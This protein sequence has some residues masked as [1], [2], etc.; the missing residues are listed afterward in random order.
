MDL[1]RQ[2]GILQYVHEKCFCFRGNFGLG[3]SSG[4]SFLYATVIV[5]AIEVLSIWGAEKVIYWN[6]DWQ[7]ESQSMRY[8][9][10]RLLS[11]RLLNSQRYLGQ[12]S[13]PYWP[14]YKAGEQREHCEQRNSGIAEKETEESGS[15]PLSAL[16]NR[17]KVQHIP[18]YLGRYV[19]LDTNLLNP[20]DLGEFEA[21]ADDDEAALVPMTLF[22]AI[23]RNQDI[24]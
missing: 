11:V 10:Q 18:T 1:V 21:A 15:S 5:C 2:H 7:C 19:P 6:K 13:I 12:R 14:S 8:F 20:N 17:A 3:G 4:R 22:L 9:V 23:L 16:G 24:A